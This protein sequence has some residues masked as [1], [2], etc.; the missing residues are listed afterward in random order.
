L[1][2]EGTLPIIIREEKLTNRR[3]MNGR[4]SGFGSAVALAVTVTVAAGL[5]LGGCRRATDADM[6]A[7][8]GSLRGV[9]ASRLAFRLEPDVEDE[10]LSIILRQEEAGAELLP[11][12][13]ADFE[14]RRGN[15]EALIRTVRDPSGH[16][17]LA[18]Y[19]TNETG[20]DFRID[21]YSADGAFI[22]N[23]LP[24]D[25]T[26]VFPGEVAWS[27]DG[28]H[29]LFSGIR[30]PALAAPGQALPSA[31]TTPAP[32]EPG[33]APLPE[34]TTAPLIPSV[35]AFSTEQV[36]V[37]DRDGFNLRPL[38]TRDGLIYFKLSWSPD[39][40]TVAAL[41]AREEEW[42]AR[43]TEAL[44]PAGRPRL[45]TLEGQERLLDDRLTPVSPVWS[46]DGTKVATA[47]DYD[48]AVYDA[49]GSAP[50]GG[51]LP[52][53]QQLRAASARY[54]ARVF[55]RNSNAQTNAGAAPA[56]K[57]DAGT[58]PQDGSGAAEAA[59][60][61]LISHNPIVRLEWIEPEKLYTQTAFVRFYSEEPMPTFKYARWHLV[62]LHP[63]AVVV[64]S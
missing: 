48:L 43:R 29:I 12:I 6:G 55:A 24:P 2:A 42:K 1:T 22:R 14:T 34:P 63:Q 30:N 9:P 19:G 32:T 41:A 52:L 51:S 38:T 20:T 45:I 39:S 60:T 64:K 3:D 10:L 18:V 28:Q 33:A 47:F 5:A 35:P 49:A 59:E 58:A 7:L 54:D 17:A 56:A 61:V 44:L 31:P 37:G 21:L 8:H 53:E 11:G 15:T 50:T 40:R 25:L 46:P 27:P 57:P 4:R 36:Y 62:H 16:R 13:K 26:G 23:V